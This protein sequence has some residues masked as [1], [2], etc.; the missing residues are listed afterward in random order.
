MK[1]FVGPCVTEKIN[2]HR[3]H[4]QTAI[5]TKTDFGAFGSRCGPNATLREILSSLNFQFQNLVIGLSVVFAWPFWWSRQTCHHIT[6]HSRTVYRNPKKARE[7][8]IPCDA[9]QKI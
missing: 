3:K 1:Y 4:H 7:G 5:I 6:R 9:H 2:L 8:E